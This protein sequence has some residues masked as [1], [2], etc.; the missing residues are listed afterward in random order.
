M[1]GAPKTRRRL[2]GPRVVSHRPR[3]VELWSAVESGKGVSHK[4]ERTKTA[5]TSLFCPIH[6]APHGEGASGSSLSLAVGVPLGVELWSIHESE[7]KAH[8]S[9]GSTRTLATTGRVLQVVVGVGE[10]REMSGVKQSDRAPRPYSA[11][12][13][14]LYRCLLF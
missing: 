7:G 2:A 14:L 4:R 11:H 13:P 1:D 12:E 3:A 6:G 5:Q 8:G 10:R 9:L